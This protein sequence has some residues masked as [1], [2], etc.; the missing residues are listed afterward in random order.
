MEYEVGL[1]L[2]L[3]V[4]DSVA[5]VLPGVM[6]RLV[7]P[8][9]TDAVAGVTVI[10]STR[11]TPWSLT[12][13]MLMEFTPAFRCTCSEECWY[14]SKLPV[15]GNRSVVVMT[16]PLTLSPICRLLT[17]GNRP[18]WKAYRQSTVYR[19]LV[20]TTTLLKVMVPLAAEAMST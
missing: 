15:I 5:V 16:V 20:G 14:V 2:A 13:S 4:Q 8:A 6:V 7:G 17:P 19:P 12:A 11:E 18:P 1:P 9:G 3:A 10:S